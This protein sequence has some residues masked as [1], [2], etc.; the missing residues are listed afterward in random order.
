M[1]DGSSFSGRREHQRPLQLSLSQ[2][3]TDRQDES[4]A[5]AE[6]VASRD[7]AL[8]NGAIDNKAFDNVLPY[9]GFGGLGK[10]Q[11]SVGLQAWID[12]SIDASVPP[13]HWGPSPRVDRPVVTA[14]WDLNDSKGHVDPVKLM[15]S[16]RDA[17]HANRGKLLPVET[18]RAF[19]LAFGTYADKMRSG[20]P[21]DNSHGRSDYVKELPSMA[22]EVALELGVAIG[23]GFGAQS[24]REIARRV[25][26]ARRDRKTLARFNGLAELLDDC[27]SVDPG[28]T[29]TDLAGDIF[30]LLTQAIDQLPASTRPLVIVFVDHVE[31]VQGEGDA[32]AGERVLNQ[33]IA[34]L[35]HALFV[36]TGRESLDWYKAERTSLEFAGASVWPCLRPD[37]ED[38]NPR[39]HL[40]GTLSEED[41]KDWIERQVSEEVLPFE[42][43][44]VNDLV[45]VTGRWPVHIDAVFA[46]ARQKVKDGATRLTR[47]ELGGSFDDV[48]RRLLESLPGDERSALQA[49]A[50][51][52]YF[53]IEL[54]HAVAGNGVTRGAIQ[55]LTQR[56][57]VLNN[58]GSAFPFRVH[59]ELRRAVRA[60]GPNVTNGWS[61]EDWY[62]KAQQAVAHAVSSAKYAR[63]AKDDEANIA[64]VGLA[65]TIAAEYSVSVDDIHE[66]H[67]DALVQARRDCPS[68]PRLIS[69]IPT[70]DRVHHQQTRALVELIE[71]IVLPVSD[72]S[73]HALER[74]AAIESPSRNDALL[75]RAY[76]LRNLNR[77]QEAAEQLIWLR[78]FADDR[79]LRSRERVYARQV[80]VTYSMARRFVDSQTALDQM[81]DGQAEV[82]LQLDL[83]AHGHI[84]D[85]LVDSYRRRINKA[86]P[87]Y[88]LEIGGALFRVLG[89][90]GDLVRTETVE[91]LQR[92]ESLAHGAAQRAALVGLA[93]HDLSAGATSFHE[94]TRGALEH[95]RFQASLG[96]ILTFKALRDGAD[97]RFLRWYESAARLDFR[98]RGWIPVE[99]LLDHIGYPLP[100]ME[101]QWLEPY[102]TV[103]A[104]WI[105]HYKRLL[106][107][108]QR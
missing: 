67:V 29:N 60:A 90:R 42:V 101:T 40:L 58:P 31:R 99:M 55:R 94:G 12:P 23:A 76:R 41:A 6:S 21:L 53:D 8:D 44:L 57:V 98:G 95:A 39:P 80:G 75:G 102:E 28:S 86:N 47:A 10:T 65:I 82:N 7:L 108:G 37:R 24:I 46:L 52:P 85:D 15:L 83:A 63:D 78:D 104:R 19:D 92:A 36:A 3:F 88:G 81:D 9:Y 66:R 61:A 49:A 4:A 64:L 56:T 26:G 96:E 70:S 27:L 34:A 32:R 45:R 11:L 73:V 16:V 25:V 38:G 68:H 50:L 48:V 20:Q 13:Q 87:R 17:L 43:G 106:N 30:Y 14:R 91:F 79:R 77:Y 18:W 69:V 54:A 74:V 72:E 84:E 5:F 51:L 105:G 22:A 33:L 107:R 62:E 59:D 35:P 71:A 2:F 89:R 103:R 97:E 100:T 93:L 1:T